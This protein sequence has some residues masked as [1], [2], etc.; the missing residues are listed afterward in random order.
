MKKK[1]ISLILV[2]LPMLAVGQHYACRQDTV[3]FSLPSYR[4]EVFWQISANGLDWSRINGSG[5]D[6]LELVAAQPAFYRSE[7]IEGMCAPVYSDIIHLLINEP[8]VVIFDPRDTACINERAFVLTGGTPAGGTA[9]GPGITEGKFNPAEAGLGLHMIFYRFK[10][11]QT[12]CSGTAFAYI[13]VLDVPNQATA[14][15]DQPFI[16]ADST[17][18]E[19]NPAEHGQGTWS[20]L[21]GTGGRF[22]DHSDP[23]TWFIKDSANLSYTLLWTIAGTCGTSSDEVSLTFFQLSKNPCQGTPYVTDADGNTYPTIQIGDQCWMAK[24][25]NTGRY[26]AST[27]DYMDHSNL[28][29]NGIIEKYCWGNDPHNCDLYGGL[30]DWDEAMGYTDTEGTRGICPEGWHLP[31]DN[32]WKTLNNFYKYGDAGAQLKVGGSSGFEAYFAGDRHAKGAFYSFGSG[33]FFWQSSSYIYLY[34]NEGYIREV[35]ACNGYLSKTHF[36]K[37]TGI[38]VRCI[39]DN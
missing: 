29:D 9:W 37:K 18:L 15:P 21:S 5:N 24:N 34:L 39:K 1:W 3:W 33:G 23:N 8:P 17:R 35:A 38:S 22:S 12:Q 6:T 26:V 16:A 28:S 27:V 2:S 19:G 14:G 36:N 32:D 11:S 7:V 13:R 30:Y 31:S 4:G 25:L 20:I 10:D